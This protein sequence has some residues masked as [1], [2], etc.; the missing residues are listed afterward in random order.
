[1]ICD[2]LLFETL[3]ELTAFSSHKG[4]SD[5]GSWISE[6]MR[7]VLH[8]LPFPQRIAYRVSALVWRCMEGFAPIYLREL[9]CSTSGVQRRSAL[10]SA[11]Q[12]ELLVPRSRTTIKQRSSFSVAGPTTWNWIP[13]ALRLVPRGHTTTFFVN[14]KT[15]LFS[16]GWTGSA[17]E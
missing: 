9:C 17:S 13:V 15:V 16:R 1:M 2:N 11:N 6:Y 4:L 7:N 12:A 3:N 10:R 8:W 14:L 5:T